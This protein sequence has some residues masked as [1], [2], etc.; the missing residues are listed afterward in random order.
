MGRTPVL[1]IGAALAAA[2]ALARPDALPAQGKSLAGNP[3]PS[4][5]ARVTVRSD[6]DTPNAYAIGVGDIVEISVWK[7]QDLGVTVPVRPDGRISVPLLGDV[8]AAGMTPLALKSTLTDGFREFVTA[9]EVSVVIKEIHSRRVF[10]TGEV[11]NPGAFDLQPRTKLMQVLA[12]AG[13]L[14]P[15]AKSKIVVLRD[16]E[17]KE[18]RRIEVNLDAIKSGKRPGDNIVL[19]PGDTVIVP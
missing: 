2:L 1:L 8:Q 3:S 5:P 15:Y 16:R 12:L 17:G 13:G 9:P 4:A 6:E 14:T 19:Q 7:N 10:V 11:A 18:D